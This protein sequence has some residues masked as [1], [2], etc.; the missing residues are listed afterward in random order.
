MRFWI[1]TAMF[2]A[3]GFTLYYLEFARGSCRGGEATHGYVH[4]HAGERGLPTEVRRVLVL[5]ASRS[6]LAAAQGAFVTGVRRCP[7]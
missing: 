4:H 5:G 6:G 7:L 1:V 3:A 2:A